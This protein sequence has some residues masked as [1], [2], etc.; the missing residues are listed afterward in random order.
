MRPVFGRVC[1]GDST[2]DIGGITERDVGLLRPRPCLDRPALCRGDR[3]AVRSVRHLW[4]NWEKSLD[5]WNDTGK[6][7]A[8]QPSA[9]GS[10][11]IE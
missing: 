8:S 3:G 9:P 6:V 1:L 5:D 10:Q 4:S 2:L 11:W 7:R